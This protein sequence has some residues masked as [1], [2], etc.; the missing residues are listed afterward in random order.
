MLLDRDFQILAL[1]QRI[2]EIFSVRTEE[3][4]G[5][6][7]RDF[8][9]G[10]RL[11][12]KPYSFGLGPPPP[13]DPHYQEDFQRLVQ[14]VPE[15]GP[16]RTLRFRFCKETG[17]DGQDLWMGMLRDISGDL[18]LESEKSLARGFEPSPDSQLAFSLAKSLLSPLN[19]VDL[20]AQFLGRLASRSGGSDETEASVQRL[21]GE[22]QRIHAILGETL[23]MQPRPD[24]HWS[25]SPLDQ[26]LENLCQVLK[27]RAR[28]QGVSIEIDL[29]ENLPP[30]RLDLSRFRRAL[31]ELLTNSLEAMPEGGT[32]TILARTSEDGVEIR[33]RDTG[34]GLSPEAQ[35]RILDPF[36]STKPQGTG[37]GLA[38][39]ARI[40]REHGGF[41]QYEN[42]PLGESGAEFR[43]T[44]PR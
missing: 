10:L 37:L 22:I 34:P 14:W 4:I 42:R 9:P 35:A 33:I 19:S 32:L 18:F 40:L 43:I 17:P 20:E 24:T 5:R 36:F 7:A 12:E 16:V 13:E 41:L 15:Q 6:D 38:L 11:A 27:D 29:E 23:Q 8:P 39:T 44:L 1:N 31:L 26:L 30:I 2:A 25:L 28:A 21:R 3:W